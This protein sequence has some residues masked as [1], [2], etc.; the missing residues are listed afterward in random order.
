MRIMIRDELSS[1]SLCALIEFLIIHILWAQVKKTHSSMGYCHPASTHLL[2]I[3]LYAS[4]SIRWKMGERDWVRWE[5]ELME[6]KRGRDDILYTVWRMWHIKQRMLCLWDRKIKWC[7]R[8]INNSIV[9]ENK[10]QYKFSTINPFIFPF[11]TFEDNVT[12]FMYRI[13]KIK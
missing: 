1:S 13:K 3:I 11:G 6:G 4:L 10:N 5:L 12:I 8:W 7:W 2:F 9:V